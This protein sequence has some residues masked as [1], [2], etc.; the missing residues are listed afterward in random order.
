MLYILFNKFL[1]FLLV[2]VFIVIGYDVKL[3]IFIN[4][5]LFFGIKMKKRLI[6]EEY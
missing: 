4:W 5:L 2:V 1:V 3:R 6:M